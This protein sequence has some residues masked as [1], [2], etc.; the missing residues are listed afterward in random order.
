MKSI[1]LSIH[2]RD[3]KGRGAMRRLRLD[4]KIPAVVYG[5]SGTHHLQVNRNDFLPVWQ[6]SL[7]SRLFI[8]LEEEGKETKLTLLKDVQRDACSGAFQHIDFWEVTRGQPLNA[9]VS[10]H[11][12]GEAHGVKNQ[13]GILEVRSHHVEV[14][15]RPSL[16]PEFIAVDISELKAGETIQL[17]DLKTSEGVEL[18]GSPDT[19]IVSCAASRLSKSLDDAEAEEDSEEQTS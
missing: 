18:I 12:L 17:K 8:E 2:H 6:Q 1:S 13:G 7:N 14:R 4:G 15:S 11:I 16:M 5:R 3:A 10:I 9:K 19:P